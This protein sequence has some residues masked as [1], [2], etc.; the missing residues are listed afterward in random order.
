VFFCGLSTGPSR[1]RNV[2]E[3]ASYGS[4]YLERESI[5]LPE[6]SIKIITM[7]KSAFTHQIQYLSHVV[8]LLR[9]LWS[10]LER[11]DISSWFDLI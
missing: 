8:T 6:K 4:T 1:K 7:E 2:M 9:S 3:S 10:S 5:S 11:V